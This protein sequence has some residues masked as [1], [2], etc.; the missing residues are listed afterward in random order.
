MFHDC[1]K[2]VNL[3][4]PIYETLQECTY[5]ILKLD[6]VGPADNKPLTN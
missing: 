1:N 5:D 2:E 4:N 3:S 6:G